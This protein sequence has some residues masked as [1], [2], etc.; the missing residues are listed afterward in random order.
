MKF[1]DFM[2]YLNKSLSADIW[3]SENIAQIIGI[4]FDDS[5]TP[6]VKSYN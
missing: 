4:E 1:H 3:F 6:S 2:D 5:L